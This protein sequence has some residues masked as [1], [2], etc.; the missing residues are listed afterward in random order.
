MNIKLHAP[1]QF[2]ANTIWDDDEGIL[3]VDLHTIPNAKQ[4]MVQ[5][6]GVEVCGDSGRRVRHVVQISTRTGELKIVSV[7]ERKTAFDSPD[8]LTQDTTDTGADS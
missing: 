3:T 5:L 4:D 1:N 6:L 7:A 2:L 8:S